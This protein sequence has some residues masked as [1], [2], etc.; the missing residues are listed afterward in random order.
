MSDNSGSNIDKISESFGLLTTIW[1]PSTWE[2][3]HCISFG[4][5]D[6]PTEDDMVDYYN[7][8]KLLRK[9]L[10]CC[11]CRQHYSQHIMSGETKLTKE[12][13]LNKNTLT[14]WLYTVHNSVDKQLGMTYNISYSDLCAKY[15]SYITDCQLTPEMKIIPYKNYYNKEATLVPYDVAICFAD[16]AK[17]RGINDF[18]INVKKT[19]EINKKSDEWSQRNEKCWSIIKNMRLNGIVCT[20]KDGEFKGLLTLQELELLQHLSTTMSQKYIK[21]I[22]KKMGYTFIVKYKLNK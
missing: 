20:E 18:E 3:L 22:L 12:V 6:N 21:H 7:F 8:F 16:Y 11:V 4:Y 15:K 14:Y 17:S 19:N 2:A 13:M 5:P 9:V 1:G 10:P